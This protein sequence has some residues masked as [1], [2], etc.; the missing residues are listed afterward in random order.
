MDERTLDWPGF[1]IGGVA[2]FIHLLMVI[3]LMS[4]ENTVASLLVFLVIA[5]SRR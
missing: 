3:G 5:S 1:L 4:F 2:I